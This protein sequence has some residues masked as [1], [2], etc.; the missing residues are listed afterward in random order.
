MSILTNFEEKR[1]FLGDFYYLEARHVAGDYS[2]IGSMKIF[3]KHLNY[4]PVCPA[5]NRRVF[6]RDYKILVVYFFNLVLIGIRFGF[7]IN[8]H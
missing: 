2:D 3:G 1:E 4:C 6:H 7:Y 8:T 5:L